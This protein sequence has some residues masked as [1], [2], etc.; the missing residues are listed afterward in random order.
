M[1]LPMTFDV[2]AH[3]EDDDFLTLAFHDNGNIPDCLEDDDVEELDEIFEEAG[4]DWNELTEGVLEI[5]KDNVDDLVA[6][7]LERG[8]EP[9]SASPDSVLVAHPEWFKE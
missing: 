7:L 4:T 6:V 3:P 9:V 5:E 8:Y 2:A 1:T